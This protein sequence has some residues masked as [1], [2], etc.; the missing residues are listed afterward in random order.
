MQYNYAGFGDNPSIVYNTTGIGGAAG[1][2]IVYESAVGIGG[3]GVVYDSGLAASNHYES[4]TSPM[5]NYDKVT[6]DNN[7][8]YLGVTHMFLFD[9]I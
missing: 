1:T 3:E 9:L 8:F 4:T 5:V 7:V 2:G 6:N